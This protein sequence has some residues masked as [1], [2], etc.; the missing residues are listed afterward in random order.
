VGDVFGVV[1]EVMLVVTWHFL[2]RSLAREEMV[3]GDRE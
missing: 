2:S 1:V 3:V